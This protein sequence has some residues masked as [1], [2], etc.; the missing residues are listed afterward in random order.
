MFSPRLTRVGFPFDRIES[1]WK[2]LI[3]IFDDR[4]F[5]KWIRGQPRDEIEEGDKLVT[6]EE[7]KIDEENS[8]WEKTESAEP[9][10]D[11]GLRPS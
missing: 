10:S 4:S 7:K 8:F 9:Q 6:D 3:Q 2:Q 1:L 11:I 5:A